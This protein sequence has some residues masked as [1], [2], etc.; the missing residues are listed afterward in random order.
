MHLT[1]LVKSRLG[2]KELVQPGQEMLKILK[3]KLVSESS[4]L[5]YRVISLETVGQSCICY[6][7]SLNQFSISIRKLSKID[8]PNPN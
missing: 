5:D 1:F 3:S 4:V 2:E 6:R 7:E 8:S